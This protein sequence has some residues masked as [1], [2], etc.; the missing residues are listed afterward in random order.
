MVPEQTRK[1][2]VFGVQ[3]TKHVDVS[4]CNSIYYYIIRVSYF[5]WSEH[6]RVTS[7]RLSSGLFYITN[8]VW[9]TWGHHGDKDSC[10]GLL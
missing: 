2:T 3:S 4:Y 6:L 5:K 8:N 7:G 1:Y 10:F 9:E